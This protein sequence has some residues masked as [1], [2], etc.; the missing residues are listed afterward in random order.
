MFFMFFIRKSMFLSSMMYRYWWRH[1][2][3]QWWRRRCIDVVRWT[4]IVSTFTVWMLSWR[5]HGSSDWQRWRLFDFH[6]QYTI[7]HF[8]PHIHSQHS[9]FHDTPFIHQRPLHIHRYV[10]TDPDNRRHDN[11]CRGEVVGDWCGRINASNWC[12]GNDGPSRQHGRPS[13]LA[14]WRRGADDVIIHRSRTSLQ[15][16]VIAECWRHYSDVDAADSI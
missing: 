3:Q 2:L 9:A 5:R 12:H 4:V 7:F 6:R 1:R 11:G 13:S 15:Y 10:I 8:T 16:D 14:R